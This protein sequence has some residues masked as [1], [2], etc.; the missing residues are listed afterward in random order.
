MNILEVKNLVKSYSSFQLK[1]INFSIEKGKI[2]G[3]IGRNGA[4]KTTL[5]KCLLNFINYEGEIKFFGVPFKENE[6]EIK[7][8]IGFVSGCFDYYSLK[9]IKQITKAISIFYSKWDNE[10]YHHYLNLFNLDENKKIKELSQGMKVKYS[11][12]LALSHNAEFLI[13]DEPTSGLDPISR[14]E[15]CDIVLNLSKAGVTVLFSTHITTDL[16]K[17]ADEIIY[18]SNGEILLNSNLNEVLNDYKIIKF[19]NLED[20]DNL[21]YKI[22]GLK[23]VKNGYE[24]LIKL[25]DCNKTS[26]EYDN[27]SLEDIMIHFELEEKMK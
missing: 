21:S 26:L 10:K 15:F 14:E 4:G 16:N 6:Q 3:L 2:V 5:L 25:E 11:I 12:A 13:L 1:N 24:G 22:I 23:E 9:T 19:K 27:A 17:I 7:E 18:I 8:K 20:V